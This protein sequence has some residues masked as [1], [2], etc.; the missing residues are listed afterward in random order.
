MSASTPREARITPDPRLGDERRPTL[1]AE[2][3]GA[4]WL[5]G[6]SLVTLKQNL[7]QPLFLV[8]NNPLI[9]LVPAPGTV[10]TRYPIEY[11]SLPFVLR[12]L[13]P[14]ICQRIKYG[15]PGRDP[16]VWGSEQVPTPTCFAR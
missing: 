12:H 1:E 3:L 7:W 6:D 11:I 13:S 2:A 16:K 9:S 5:K 14:Q 15:T 10:H 8:L 4:P